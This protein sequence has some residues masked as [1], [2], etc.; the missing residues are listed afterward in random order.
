MRLLTKIFHKF[1]EIIRDQRGSPLMEEALL[2][3]VSLLMISL[4]LAMVL[5]VVGWAQNTINSIYNEFDKIER[6]ISGSEFFTNLNS[7][8][9]Q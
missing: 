1:K 9:M 3:G 5:D 6:G 2:I 7:N 8:Y 4:L